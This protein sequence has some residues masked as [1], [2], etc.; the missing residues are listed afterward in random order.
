MSR[1]IFQAGVLL[2]NMT[3]DEDWL[4]C[5]NEIPIVIVDG[6][7]ISR[8]IK[9]LPYKLP[10]VTPVVYLFCDADI[11]QLQVSSSKKTMRFY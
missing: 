2:K 6:N 7:T 10:S 4:R 11:F 5:V 1:F 9:L 8:T 3:I